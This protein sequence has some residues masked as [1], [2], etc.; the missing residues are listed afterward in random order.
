MRI[1]FRATE[2]S[3]ASKRFRR[4]CEGLSLH[5]AIHEQRIGAFRLWVGHVRHLCLYVCTCRVLGI[6]FVF[7]DSAQQLQPTGKSCGI[8][9]YTDQL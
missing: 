9:S 6:F 5:F 7:V 8:E 1:E 2:F 4:S 3:C